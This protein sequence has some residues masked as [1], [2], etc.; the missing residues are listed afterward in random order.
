MVPDMKYTIQENIGSHFL[1][2]AVQM[3]KE[4]KTFVLVLDN[5]DWEVKVHDMRSDKQNK[6]VHAVAT[7]IVFDRVASDLPDNGP[8]KS[9]SDCDMKD[10]L[11]LTDEEQRC[12][13]ERYKIFLGRILCELFPAF[14][15]LIGVVLERTPCRYQAEMSAQSVVVPLPVL[16]KDEKKYAEVVDV[17]DQLEVWVCACTG[18]SDFKLA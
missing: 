9:L 4:G 16:M 12:T 10:L 17:L 3:V 15:F 7:S 13:R 5:I 8:K 1:D 14:Q 2:H 18:K 11:K 6:S